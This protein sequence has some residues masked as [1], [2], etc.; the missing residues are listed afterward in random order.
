MWIPRKS[1]PSESL[2]H[3]FESTAQRSRHSDLGGE[4][5]VP[6]SKIPESDA[7]DESNRA[8]KSLF[9]SKLR[10]PQK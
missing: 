9:I 10:C 5:R 2:L 3:K 1:T 7:E 6:S 8:D 4:G